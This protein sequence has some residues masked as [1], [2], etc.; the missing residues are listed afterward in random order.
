MAGKGKKRHF[1]KTKFRRP[2]DSS[3]ILFIDDSPSSTHLSSGRNPNSNSRSN[4]KSKGF[5]RSKT[6]YGSSFNYAYPDLGVQVGMGSESF[7]RE[8]GEKTDF[9]ESSPL[10]IGGSK[11]SPIV[12]FVDV[13]PSTEPMNMGLGY[14]YNYG[15]TSSMVFD[16]CSHRGLG[17][18]DD[19]EETP[20]GIGSSP[21]K[22]EDVDGLLS[23]S[24]TLHD[25]EMDAD[26]S[27]DGGQCGKMV[28]DLMDEPL[29]PERE[30]LSEQVA[31]MGKGLAYVTPSPRKNAGF[32]SIG[33]MKLYTEDI[34]DGEGEEDV[35]EESF[36]GENSESSD[37]DGT[38]DESESDSDID[39]EIMEDYLQG[40]GGSDEFLDIKWLAGEDLD[41][42]EDDSS[43]SSL[44]EKLGGIALQDASREYGMKK[45]R[46]RK[47]N[48]SGFSKHGSARDEWPL[49]SD[50]LMIVK[51]ARRMMAKTKHTVQFPK[52]W[53]SE[54]Q[55]GRS[56]RDIRVLRVLR[57]V[58]KLSAGCNDCSV[59]KLLLS[60][61]FIYLYVCGKKKHRKE[62]IAAKR[63]DRMIR[64]GV[65]L[66]LINSI[67]LIS[68]E[69][70]FVEDPMAVKG[71]KKARKKRRRSWW[72][73]IPFTCIVS[74][75]GTLQSHYALR[76][77]I[78]FIEP[79]LS[80][81]P[82]VHVCGEIRENGVGP[83]GHAIIPSHA[84][85]GLF[86][87]LTQSLENQGSG[88]PLTVTEETAIGAKA[89]INIWASKWLSRL[90]KE[91]L[92]GPGTGDADFAV[93]D[94]SS[95]KLVK[96]DKNRQNRSTKGSSSGPSTNRQGS[97]RSREKRHSGK[98]GSFADQPVSFVSSGILNSETAE[99]KTLASAS[100]IT[101]ESLSE[102][103]AAGS[104]SKVGAFELH[105][106][107]FGSKMM[108]KMGYV[109]GEGLG[110]DGQG[111]AM[112]IDVVMRPKS[113]GLG[114]EFS[115]PDND[116]V[117]N[118]SVRTGA[119]KRH[120]KGTGLKMTPESQ[121]LG[122]FEKHT[123]GFGS[124]MMAKM[125]FVEG[126]GLGSDSQGMITPLLAVRRP[127]LRGLGAKA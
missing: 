122:A 52:S 94:P 46:S 97:G 33:S 70:G 74:L 24:L 27:L 60:L 38:D 4:S 93:N 20:T 6:P 28:E 73:F 87:V 111:M 8:N 126:M 116:I 30:I 101:S 125:G 58:A 91:K 112:P 86:P 88:F 55:K 44:D 47:K 29:S 41:A 16:D 105:T 106:K 123:K 51:D 39:E 5:D 45:P 22:K 72:T 95:A 68:R 102:S 65:D 34:S 109:E 115:E 23:S 31:K 12:A 66:N 57:T 84:F 104:V 75:F 92:L 78:K 32:V 26:N 9:N 25:K 113:L 82:S 63:R 1:G 59:N 100:E 103:K 37:S 36:N 62:M 81:H 77:E 42:S 124:K 49:R 67:R 71:R 2:Q 64:R 10:V 127:K 54:S 120:N 69:E 79:S 76:I 35:S 118:E 121:Q 107:G 15:S 48:V 13:I 89:S 18:D 90:W 56:F 19:V 110:K 53:P 119:P 7:I 17:F 61:L 85:Q 43:T 96:R 3:P 11:E 21:K 99:T 98:I 117:K 40:I 108:A 114:M 80:F 83:T 14:N 50:E